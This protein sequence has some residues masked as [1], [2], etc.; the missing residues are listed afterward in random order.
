M[1]SAGSPPS[2]SLPCIRAT[3]RRRPIGI[4]PLRAA[5]AAPSLPPAVRA[6]PSL[7]PAIQSSAKSAAQEP[8]EPAPPPRRRWQQAGAAAAEDPIGPS[9][10]GAVSPD[11]AVRDRRATGARR[12][13]AAAGTSGHRGPGAGAGGRAAGAAAAAQ[14]LRRVRAAGDQ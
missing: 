3:S 2:F 4:A 8:Q 9:V 11:R 7:T 1:V 12:R 6:A 5:A 13:A 10:Q 14:D